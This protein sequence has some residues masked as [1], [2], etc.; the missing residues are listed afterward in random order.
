MIVLIALQRCV[1]KHVQKICHDR[2]IKEKILKKES[3]GNKRRERE[4]GDRQ[5]DLCDCD[6]MDWELVNQRSFDDS[7]LILI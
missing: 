2:I 3:K 1:L 7:I 6:C 4:T 5:T